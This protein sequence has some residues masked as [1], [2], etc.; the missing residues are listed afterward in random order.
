MKRAREVSLA[1][2]A[3]LY[4]RAR[5]SRTSKDMWALLIH[6]RTKL[7]LGRDV[8]IINKGRLEIG[9]T[10]PL[11]SRFDSLLKLGDGATLVVNGDFKIYTGCTVYVNEGATLELGSGYISN[12]T[13]ISCF[14]RISIGHGVA[15]SEDVT[16]RDSDNHY[17]LRPGYEP[18][19]SVEI[20][21]HV[22]IG[23][24]AT[25]LKGVK[26]GS[27]SVVAAGAVVTRDVP[28]NCLVGGVPARVIRRDVH[29]R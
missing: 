12:N 7:G 22:W 16:I 3:R 26:I 19:G 18:D 15:I 27:G 17:I 25:I 23:I 4:L 20:G 6:R 1:R 28:K 21:D 9:V 8:R 14:N 29:W 10:W 11:C 2:S 5:A 24:R 13:N